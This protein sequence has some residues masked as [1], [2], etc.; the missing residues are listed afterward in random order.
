MNHFILQVFVQA[1]HAAALPPVQTTD[2]IMPT[3]YRLRATL[4]AALPPDQSIQKWIDPKGSRVQ[5]YLQETKGPEGLLGSGSC[6]QVTKVRN[7]EY[8][9]N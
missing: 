5:Y 9:V 6:G 3:D 1:N 7:E 8:T 2:C 4:P